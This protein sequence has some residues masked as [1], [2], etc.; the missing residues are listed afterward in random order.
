MA[1]QMGC[2]DCPDKIVGNDAA[3]VD[4]A[5]GA[6]GWKM[7]LMPSGQA[8]YSCPECALGLLALKPIQ[9]VNR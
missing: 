2:Y 9:Q 5:A 6:A 4:R 7:G 8:Y 1:W 3:E